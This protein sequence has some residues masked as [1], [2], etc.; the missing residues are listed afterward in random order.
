MESDEYC[1]RELVGG[2]ME[3]TDDEENTSKDCVD[4][5]RGDVNERNGGPCRGAG[6]VGPV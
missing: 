1:V 5:E 3:E 4:D 2:E 6:R